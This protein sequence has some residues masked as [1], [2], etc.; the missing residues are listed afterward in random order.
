L[1]FDSFELDKQSAIL[2][3]TLSATFLPS[4]LTGLESFLT[5][6]TCLTG[7]TG[8]VATRP[9]RTASILLNWAEILVK[10]DIFKKFFI[11]F[12]NSLGNL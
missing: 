7:L 11:Q 1:N 9:L 10:V 6:L 5:G 8:L 3:V 12:Y 2:S 4:F